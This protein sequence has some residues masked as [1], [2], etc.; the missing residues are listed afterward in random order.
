MEGSNMDARIIPLPNP[1]INDLSGQRFGRLCVIGYVG[2]SAS[3]KRHAQYL[4]KC[5]CGNEKI[6]NGYD[7]RRGHAESCG[8]LQ[9]ERSSEWRTVENTTHGLRH[10]PEYRSWEAMKRRCLVEKDSNYEKYGGRGITVCDR[11]L[12]SFEAFYEDMGPKPSPDHS[13][14]RKDND[15]NYE[16]SN[17]RWA[18]AEEQAG[19]RRP[20]SR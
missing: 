1:R 3:K 6:A 19:N 14:D 17:C 7:L 8:C 10:V 18:T 2:R 20:R 9:S 11:W 4:C 13:I 16:P 15:G 5:D 12:N